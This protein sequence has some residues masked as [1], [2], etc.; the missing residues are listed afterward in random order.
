MNENH[1]Y[2][3]D[4]LR[5]Y[6]QKRLLNLAMFVRPGELFHRELLKKIGIKGPTLTKLKNRLN[7]SLALFS[8]QCKIDPPIQLYFQSSQRNVSNVGTHL[9][10]T[11]T[12]NLRSS[13]DYIPLIE[14]RCLLTQAT[15]ALSGQ[16][17]EIKEAKKKNEHPHPSPFKLLAE[18]L[19]ITKTH[20]PINY[21]LLSIY[22]RTNR[23]RSEVTRILKTDKKYLITGKPGAG[24]TMLALAI[25]YEFFRDPHVTVYYHDVSAKSNGTCLAET[26]KAY[27]GDV[28]IILDNVYGRSDEVHN[29]LREIGEH[30]AMLLL[31]ASKS[32]KTLW[33]WHFNNN[34]PYRIP[35]SDISSFK[36]W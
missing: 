26:I 10:C 5:D 16:D 30:Q 21:H 17:A 18:H 35:Y 22:Y 34:G 13:S 29:F 19:A 33:P 36:K 27:D 3:Y 11:L 25:G 15:K 20:N 4:T 14:L 2:L 8:E 9:A 12:R 6:K 23:L 1:K 31:V 28:L 32:K 7:R 24:K